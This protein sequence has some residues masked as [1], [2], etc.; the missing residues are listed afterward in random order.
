MVDLLHLSYAIY[1]WSDFISDSELSPAWMDHFFSHVHATSVP[2]ASAPC[3]SYI[4]LLDCPNY[5]EK[6]KSASNGQC[7]QNDNAG[8]TSEEVTAC[9][10]DIGSI[11]DSM[12]VNRWIID[13]LDWDSMGAR[14]GPCASYINLLDFRNYK[15]KFKSASMGQ[16]NQN[17]NADRTVTAVARIRH[18][19]VGSATLARMNN[20]G[21][22]ME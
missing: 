20:I 22:R 12:G 7:N 13:I 1:F 18:S 5:K 17:D 9:S 16:C 6:F 3:G 11:L 4:N 8:R 19:R 15:V 14:I 21:Q 2:C 10:R